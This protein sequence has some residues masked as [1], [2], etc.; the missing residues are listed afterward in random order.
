MP[1]AGLREHHRS[2]PSDLSH[3]QRPRLSALLTAVC[4]QLCLGGGRGRCDGKSSS[5]NAN[6]FFSPWPLSSSPSSSDDKKSAVGS[7]QLLPASASRGSGAG[8]MFA[9]SASRARRDRWLCFANALS[10]GMD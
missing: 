1:L 7:S 6:S 4:T 9:P 3:A 5:T 8:M 10:S 2:L